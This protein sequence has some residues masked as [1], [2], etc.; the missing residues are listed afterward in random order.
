MPVVPRT[1]DISLVTYLFSGTYTVYISCIQANL[2]Q[3][4]YRPHTKLSNIDGI[5]LRDY[6]NIII[7]MLLHV[8]FWLIYCVYFI[9]QANLILQTCPILKSLHWLKVNE[10]IEYKLLSLLPTKF[11]QPLNLAIFTTLSLFNLLAVPALHLLSLFLA[12]QPS[13]WKS[14]IAHSYMR[15]QHLVFRISFQIHFVS[16]TSHQS[17]LDSPP[18]PRVNPSL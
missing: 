5:L 16:F 8:I 7:F 13:P 2:T 14:Q 3:Q 4:M 9:I 15:H 18:H 12:R 6:V 10:R 17:C 11:L 1:A